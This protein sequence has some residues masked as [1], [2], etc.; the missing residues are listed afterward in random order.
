VKTSCRITD[1]HI[2]LSCFRCIDRIKDNR[3]RVASLLTCNDLNTCPV[4]PL[5]ELLDR[6]GTKGIGCRQN[7]LFA[8]CLK[9]ACQL[10]DRG[11]FSNA[12]YADHQYHRGLMLKLIRRFIHLHLLL[13]RIHQKLSAYGNLFDLLFLYLFLEILND[14]VCRSNTDISHDQDLLQ[15]L[16]EIVINL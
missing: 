5:G 13:D 2:R 14:P 12:V 6:R 9:L 7:D 16:I 3:C 11:C 10:A 4:R 15:L 1:Q 8:L